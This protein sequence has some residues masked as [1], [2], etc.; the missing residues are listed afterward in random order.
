MITNNTLCSKLDIRSALGDD[1]RIITIIDTGNTAI[2][3]SKF[4]LD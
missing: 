2:T 1:K 3:A 4:S